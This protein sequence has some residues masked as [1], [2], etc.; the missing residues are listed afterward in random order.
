MTEDTT[1]F[2][3]AGSKTKLDWISQ[4]DK[5]ATLSSEKLWKDTFDD[6]LMERLKTRY[7]NPI[8]LLQKQKTE[9]GEGF[10]IVSIQCAVI[11]FLAALKIGKNYVFSSNKNSNCGSHEY[12]SSSKLF[13]DFLTKEP[14]FKETL[15][16]SGSAKLFYQEVRC[17]LLHEAMTKGGWKILARGEHAIDPKKKIV[18]RD[19]LQDAIGEYLKRYE[20]ELIKCNALQEAFIRKFDHLAKD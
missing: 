11:E 17:A 1:K 5:L 16:S 6:F 20:A 10:A 4:R 19:M 7:F 13:E 9:H 12:T 14:P 2:K 18:N 3:I 8:C 15:G